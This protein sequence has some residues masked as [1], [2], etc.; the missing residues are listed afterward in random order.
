MPGVVPAG[1]D[2]VIPANDISSAS[3]SHNTYAN[4]FAKLVSHLYF[5]RAVYADES[6]GL[7]LYT[8]YRGDRRAIAKTLY[9]GYQRI[10]GISPE[11][12]ADFRMLSEAQLEAG[13]LPLTASVIFT[14]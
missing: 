1:A 10:I 5:V 3:M 9:V 12:V 2:A 4:D 8:V 11:V 6:H 14:K 13:L 7:T